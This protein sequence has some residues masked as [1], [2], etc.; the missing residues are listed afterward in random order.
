LVERSFAMF[1]SILGTW[2]P[3]GL[4]FITTY[5][6]GRWVVKAAAKKHQGKNNVSN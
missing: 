2:I 1:G 3:F 6:T 5:L 4:I